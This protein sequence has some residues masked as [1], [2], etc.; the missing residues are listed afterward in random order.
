[1]VIFGLILGLLSLAV[2]APVIKY[3]V[4]G[5]AI[6]AGVFVVAIIIKILMRI[7]GKK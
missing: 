7:F 2:I 4:I 3:A 5:I 1:M 6:I